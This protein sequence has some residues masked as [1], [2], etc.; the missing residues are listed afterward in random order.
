VQVSNTNA[1]PLHL[2]V[3]RFGGRVSERPHRGKG[4][5]PVYCWRIEREAAAEFLRTVLPWLIV[6]RPQAELALEFAAGPSLRGSV[7]PERRRHT[8]ARREE[9]R[10]AMGVL[11][12]RGPA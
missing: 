2:Y 7:P 12:R 4:W 1:E 8:L 10:E 11:N 6:K 3:E 9:C 5:K